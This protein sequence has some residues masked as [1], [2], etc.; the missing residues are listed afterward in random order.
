[1]CDFQIELKHLLQ[2]LLGVR[3]D[4]FDCVNIQLSRSESVVD[5]HALAGPHHHRDLGF[6]GNLVSSRTRITIE[7][8][9]WCV[10]DLMLVGECR[11]FRLCIVWIIGDKYDEGM[12]RIATQCTSVVY[13]RIDLLDQ[14]GQVVCDL[15]SLNVDH[16]TAAERS[17]PNERAAVMPL[18]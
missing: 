17:A 7:Y 2:V 4:L 5:F 18:S 13:E 8:G 12:L 11:E 10:L 6:F 14:T 1:M 9:Q 16:R 15:T 3:H